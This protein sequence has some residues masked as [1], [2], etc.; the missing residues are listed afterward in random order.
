MPLFLRHDFCSDSGS[1]G[2]L[3]RAAGGHL[4]HAHTSLEDRRAITIAGPF[5]P[6][7]DLIGAIDVDR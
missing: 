3:R 6:L 2:D 7:T 4:Q 5:Q 1:L